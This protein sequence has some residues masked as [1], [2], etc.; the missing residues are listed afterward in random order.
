MTDASADVR[1]LARELVSI[2]SHDGEREAGDRIEAWLREHTAADVTRD[3]AGVDEGR[4]GN[5][6]AR[7]GSG[8]TTLALVGH[9]DVVPPDASQVTDDGDY[10]V[11]TA[12][13]GAGRRL[14][15]R[16]SADMKGAVAAA[17]CAFRD[18]EVGSSGDRTESGDADPGDGVELVFASFVGEEAGGV[19]ARAA[20][21]RGFEPDYAVV[22]E[23]STGYSAPGV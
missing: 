20:I 2:P 4:G 9:H 16:G 6:V 22:G 19:G 14:S 12:G 3:D 8:D 5:V 10:V 17:M 11:E 18:S 7:K 23:G 15:G 13:E 1:E 21:D